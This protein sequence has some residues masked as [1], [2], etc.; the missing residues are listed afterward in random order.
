MN[1]SL[2]ISAVVLLVFL[3]NPGH[4]L[5]QTPE[6][7]V[8]QTVEIQAAPAP[9]EVAPAAALPGLEAFVDGIIEGAMAQHTALPGITVSVVEEGEVILL[10]GY[11]LANVEQQVPVDPATSL[12]RI[13]SITKTFTGLAVMQL[14]EQ[15]KLDLDADVNTYLTA[16]KIPDTFPEPITLGA[17]ISHRA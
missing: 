17:L 2:H 3:T 13:G 6:Q 8:P 7:P 14:V 5:A 4:S 12:F 11:G 15:G 16:F 1:K 10:K 9:E